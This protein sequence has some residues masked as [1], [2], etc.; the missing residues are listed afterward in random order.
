M[1][2]IQIKNKV[3]LFDLDGTLINSM[4]Y[5]IN[6]MINILDENGI[7][8][9]SNIVEIITPLG[10]EGT[11]KYFINNLGIN[12][13]IEELVKI[14]VKVLLDKYQNEIPL[15]EGVYKFVT[16]LKEK[17]YKLYVLTASPHVMLDSCLKRVGIYD[18]FEKVWSCDDFKTTKADV[19]IYKMVAK[20]IGVKVEDIAFFDD[21][22][23]SIKTGKKAGCYTIGVYDVSGDTF[24][25]ELTKTADY[26][27][28]N[29]LE[30]IN[31][32]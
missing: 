10:Y 23:N 24:R 15:K 25:G 8:Y 21:N 20:E 5:F 17:G 6:T 18:L 26:Y 11:A 32:I 9:P 1:S 19:N 22:I 31:E 13:P 30:I 7:K 12:E 14:M 2:K 28:T 29:F 4:P 16:A 3:C 27:V